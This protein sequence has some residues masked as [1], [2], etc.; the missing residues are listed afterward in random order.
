[1]AKTPLRAPDARERIRIV[2]ADDHDLYR[3]GMRVVI[4]HE[5]DLEVVAEVAACADAVAKCVELEPEVVL[6]GHRSPGNTGIEAC[7]DIARLSPRT[8]I[9]ILASDDDGSDLVAAV[10]AGATG[11]L[12]KDMTTRQI[13]ESVR[14]AHGGQSL[15]P[16]H[17]VAPLQAELARLSAGV[18][19]E[20]QSQRLTKR[21][22]EVLGLVARG[23]VNKEIAK[24]LFISENTVKNHVRSLMGKL[25]VSSRV[26]A[27][28]YGFEQGFAGG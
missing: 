12:L 8:K 16:S 25:K 1:M 15:I 20:D 13:I 21:E 26:E 2:I 11:Y 5:A 22:R 10:Q 24:R 4:G 3:R 17:M 14:L 9:L 28:L 27:A 18:P 7:E 19:A 23:M 6:L